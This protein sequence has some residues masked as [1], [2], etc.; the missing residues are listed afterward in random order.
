[1]TGKRTIIGVLL[2]LLAA[3]GY[4]KFRPRQLTPE[5]QVRR[6]LARAEQGAE[7]Q[8]AS[9]CMAC[10]S[11]DYSDS[12]GNTYHTL[13]QLAVRGF[14]SVDAVDVTVRVRELTVRGDRA[15]VT[16]HVTISAGQHDSPPSTT[17]SDMTVHLVREKQGWRRQWK[18]VRV[19][20]WNFPEV[21]GY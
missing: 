1:M 11:R 10:V 21:D 3:A 2:V 14:Y 13:R 17:D 5:A 7:L 6:L 9:R 8:S 12:D 16:A 4:W 18:V 19:K 20:G 15:V